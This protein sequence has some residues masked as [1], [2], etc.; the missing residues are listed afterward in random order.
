MGRTHSVHAE[1]ITFGLKLASWAFELDRDRTRLRARRPTTWPR[2]RSRGP[3]APTRQLGPDV[4]AAA[5][6]ALGLRADPVSTQIVQRDRHA[7]FLTAIA[8]TGGSIE[9]FATEVRNLQHTEIA[10][11]QEPFR[12]GQKGSSA[13]PHKRNPIL[14][15]RLA[16][17]ARLLRGFALAGMEDQALWHE[18]DISHS[19]VERVVLPGATTLLHYMLVRFRGLVDGP[20]GATRADARE[21]RARPGP[22]RVEPAA[23]RARRGRRPVPRGCV[24]DR[25]AHARACGRRAA[26]VARA[27]GR[28]PGG[29]GRARRRHGSPPASTTSW[30]SVTRPRSWRGWT[31]CAARREVDVAVDAAAGAF[32][33]SGKVRDLYALDE[34]R[35]LLVASDRISAFDVVLPT[36]IPDKGRVLTG[37]SRYWFGRPRGLVADHLLGTGPD[38]A[39]G[40]LARRGRRAPRPDHDLPPGGAPAGRDHRAR[41]PVGQW[42]AGLPAHGRRVAACRCRP[43]CVESDRLP[44]PVFTPSTKA[45]TGHDQNIDF[46][47][48]VALVGGPVAERARDI[49]LACLPSGRRARGAPGHPAGRHQDGA[50][51]SVPG[52]DEPQLLLIDEVMTPDSSRFWEPD[53][54][55]AGPRPGVASTSSSCATGCCARTGTRRRP[56]RSCRTTSSTGTRARYVEAFERLTG[57]SFADYLATDTVTSTTGATD[58]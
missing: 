33:R 14:S 34:D 37:L 23:D 53:D 52:R 39:A 26:A 18:R 55:A 4:E 24:R 35:L 1:P 46:D 51:H 58:P 27:A 32:L 48:L 36:P 2:A 57:A 21:H 6:A 25:P 8:V 43:A 12:Q 7:A 9:R 29:R 3:S 38:G 11:L 28:R 17:L 22:P 16:G 10:E 20:R 30:R 15:E 56:A 19:S 50:G 41:L 5:L 13:M 47:A 54:V 45:E 42:L 49:A 40:R 44:E 31:S